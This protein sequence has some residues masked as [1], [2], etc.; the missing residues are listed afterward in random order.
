MPGVRGPDYRVP[1]GRTWRVS[2]QLSNPGRRAAE[3]WEVG[4]VLANEAAPLQLRRLRDAVQEYLPKRGSVPE[5]REGMG[6]GAEPA[7]S[8]T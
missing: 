2:K 4:D 5:L 6:E 8:T 3:R 7:V 1:F